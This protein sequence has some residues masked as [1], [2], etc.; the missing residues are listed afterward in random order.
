MKLAVYYS[1][2][3]TPA[4][5]FRWLADHGFDAVTV[6]DQPD[7]V[8]EARRAGLEAWICLGTFGPTA[9]DDA[10]LCVGLDGARH[11][12][13]GSGCPNEPTI[14]A[15]S[16]ER[17]KR[18]AS[19]DGVAG[20]F[21][22]GIRYAS[23][24]SGLE[25][26]FTCFCTRCEKA[27]KTMGLDF[28][29]MRADVSIIHERLKQGRLPFG[30]PLAGSPAAALGP[31]ASMPG[32]VDWLAFRARVITDF[33]ALIAKDVHAQGVKLGGYIFS[34]C[35][36]PL[37]GQDYA[38]MAKHVD[39]FAPM[40]YRNARELNSIAPV[41]TE[42]HTMA[43]WCTEDGDASVRWVLDFFGLRG[44]GV[45][46]RAD[47]LTA[48]LSAGDM[49]TETE[50]ARALIGADRELA[51]IIWWEDDALPETIA[52]HRRGG[53]DGVS[54]FL[55]REQIKQHFKVSHAEQD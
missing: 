53:A 12:W 13:F 3:T 33:I 51:P 2:V 39:L 37:V 41:N 50:R 21:M 29:R 6:G 30:A 5:D 24:A 36:A 40:M 38:A 54:I 10:Q 48:G 44:D 19:R 52:A 49:Q 34:P 43:S 22:D 25:P 11:K 47:L 1:T 8:A 16:L 17:Y 20:V 18:A 45:D 27:A 7:L 9:D 14:R 4:E 46:D 23:P 55:F 15:A 32:V 42:I 35:L 31:L 26:F 28:K